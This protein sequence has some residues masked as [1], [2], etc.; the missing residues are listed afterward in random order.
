[1][2]MLTIMLHRFMTFAFILHPLSQSDHVFLL[3][4]IS[5]IHPARA[6][7]EQ[8]QSAWDDES[9]RERMLQREA[10]RSM[11]A[12]NTITAAEKSIRGG[13]SSSGGGI[14]QQPY[15]LEGKRADESSK[16]FKLRI[17][18]ET[19]KTLAV[20][21]QKL[22]STAQKRKARLKE[23]STKRKQKKGKGK[24]VDEYQEVRVP[25]I[26]RLW[27]G[28]VLSCACTYPCHGREH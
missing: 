2:V 16:D 12:D 21:L 17:R 3:S 4:N 25:A 19:R 5:C 13:S 11:R 20:E 24:N 15:Q 22:T 9:Q 10:L 26:W 23:R 6:R 8:K 27:H 28:D 7:Q 1:M 14:N 18:Q